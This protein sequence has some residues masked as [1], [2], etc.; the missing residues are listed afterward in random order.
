MLWQLLP[1]SIELNFVVLNNCQGGI[2]L[3][4]RATNGVVIASEKKVMSVL[5]DDESMEK[6]KL[7]SSNVGV[8]YSGMGPDFRVLA[9]RGRKEAQKYFLQYKD[10]VPVSQLVREVASVMQVFPPFECFSTQC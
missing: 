1:R 2:S 4:I 6:I 9:R 7:F 8:A 5:V 3:G 10:I